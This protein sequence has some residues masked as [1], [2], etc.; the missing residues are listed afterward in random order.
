L[1]DLPEE[2]LRAAIEVIRKEAGENLSGPDDE[3]G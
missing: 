3:E 1:N 2:T